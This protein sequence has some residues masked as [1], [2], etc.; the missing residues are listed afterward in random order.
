L[1]D[2]IGIILIVKPP[3]LLSALGYHDMIFCLVVK[4]Y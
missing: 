1:D 3:L 4:G 2:C